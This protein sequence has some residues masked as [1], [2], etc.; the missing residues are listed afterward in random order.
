M[1]IVKELT[2]ELT[3]LLWRFLPI[4]NKYKS[5]LKLYLLKSFPSIFKSRNEFY[6]C[7]SIKPEISVGELPTGSSPVFHQP[8]AIVIHAYYAEILPIICTYLEGTLFNIKIFITVPFEQET[9]T[10]SVLDS[11]GIPYRL[12]VTP[13]KGRDILPFLSIMPVVIKEG[14]EL[15]LKVHTKKSVHLEHGAYIRQDLYKKLLSPIMV[16]RSL[17][18]FH[19]NPKL[20]ILSAYKHLVPMTT[21]LKE[22]KNGI[23]A[24]SMRLC[25]PWKTVVKQA[26]P[27]GSMFYAR[28]EA[29]VP[30][31][32]LKLDKTQF[33]EED[34]QTD[35]TL[36][37]AIER[38]FSI[39]AYSSNMTVACISY[40]EDD[41]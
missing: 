40:L 2:I 38:C 34:Q 6:G 15:I 13:N 39:S 12:M 28:T 1:C 4:T 17:Q 24:L 27:A 30:L 33:E 35:G 20:G 3:Y 32:N 7:T 23:M 29:L 16:Q 25:V 10:R 5:T 31:M 9:Y 26:F 41:L 21:Y 11:T 22:N 8:L 37:H 18:A 14:F 36:S 19:E